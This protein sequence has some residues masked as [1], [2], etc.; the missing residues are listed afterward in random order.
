[1]VGKQQFIIS[2]QIM[3]HKLFSFLIFVFILFILAPGEVLAHCPLCVAGAGAGI[4]LSRLLGIDDSITGIWIGA[5]IGATSFWMQRILGSKNPTFLK[6]HFG[7]LFY[8]FLTLITI[9]SFYRFNLVARHTDIFGMDK[10]TFGILVGS[11]SFYIIDVFNFYI[12]Q[13]RGK[14]LF[15]YQS[16]I[17][18]LGGL[19]VL[20]VFIFI[21]INF[22]I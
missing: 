9:F 17:F 3:K 11:V 1:M 8:I 22:F 13:K 4:T 2:H 6:R 5:F 16:L 21:L 15:P 10:L 12:K 18:S 14:S 7:I 19:T 20:S